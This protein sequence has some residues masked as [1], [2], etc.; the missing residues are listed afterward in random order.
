MIPMQVSHP[1]VL[2]VDDESRVLDGLALVLR[3]SPCAV[4]S[5]QSA[6]E[7]LGILNRH[8]VDVVVSDERMPGMCGSELLSIVSQ[9]FP[10]TGRI[11]LTGQATV[12]TAVRAINAGRICRFLQKPCQPE[13][14]LAAVE[15]AYHVAMQTSFCTRLLAFARTEGGA[16]SSDQN[17]VLSPLPPKTCLRPTSAPM[18]AFGPDLLATLSER[19]REVLDL[20]VDGMRVAQVGKTLFISRHTVR[21]HLKSIFGKLD[22]HSQAELLSK[23]RGRSA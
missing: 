13:E 9:A 7:A 11:L 1:T 21:S 17:N 2:I 20:I 5:A 6:A 22:V 3:R 19:E 8:K 16:L 10:A 12:E 18:G 23:G 14:F 4:L 15:A